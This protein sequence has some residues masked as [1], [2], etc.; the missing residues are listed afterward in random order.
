MYSFFGG[1]FFFLGLFLLVVGIVL[2][3]SLYRSLAKGQK[4]NDEYD[5]EASGQLCGTIFT[6][7]LV[8][9]LGTMILHVF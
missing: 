6:I 9:T 3:A 8:L 7:G 2:G 5:L 4:N 1:F